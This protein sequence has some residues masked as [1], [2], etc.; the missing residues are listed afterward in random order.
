MLASF[1]LRCD[2]EATL[3]PVVDVWPASA[4][5]DGP[6]PP[7]V[8]ELAGLARAFG[9]QVSV[10][11]SVGHVPHARL[12]TPSAMPKTL[13]SVRCAR[14]ARRAVAVRENSSWHSLWTWSTTEFFRK[15]P[16]LEEF[17]QALR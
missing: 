13:W 2:W 7:P 5:L 14:D 17:R 6:P 10:V 15:L 4:P 12:G 16:L 9:W 8:A 1:P 11:G 3:P